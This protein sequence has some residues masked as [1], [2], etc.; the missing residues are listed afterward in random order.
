MIAAIISVASKIRWP[1]RFTEKTSLTFTLVHPESLAQYTSLKAEGKKKL[2]STK[3]QIVLLG[4]H[5][6][7]RY[8][9]GRVDW[10]KHPH[11]KDN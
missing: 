8:V 9:G 2:H 3:G 4:K 1:L 11:F 10:M 7:F 6:A 5:R